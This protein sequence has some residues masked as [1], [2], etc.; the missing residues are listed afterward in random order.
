MIFP[1]WLYWNLLYV[2]LTIGCSCPVFRNISTQFFVPY[3]FYCFSLALI[4]I[5]KFRTNCKL[6]TSVSL[7]SLFGYILI[8]RFPCNIFLIFGTSI[9]GIYRFCFSWKKFYYYAWKSHWSN[10]F[11]CPEVLITSIHIPD[12]SI[13]LTTSLTIKTAAESPFAT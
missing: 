7:Q 11:L 2:Y 12:V 10:L 1:R 6:F 13:D 4:F 8:C 9:W 3:L 5:Y